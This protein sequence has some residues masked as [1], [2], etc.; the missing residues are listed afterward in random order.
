[1]SDELIHQDELLTTGVDTRNSKLSIKVVTTPDSDLRYMLGLDNGLEPGITF[2][3]LKAIGLQYSLS[4]SKLQ[5]PWPSVL[6]KLA[7][8]QIVTV[9][10]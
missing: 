3:R 2:V 7:Q 8:H 5:I 1:M 4:K 6:C 9:Y 10:Y